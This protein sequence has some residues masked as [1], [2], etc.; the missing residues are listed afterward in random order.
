MAPF[1]FWSHLMKI[2][3]HHQERA[4]IVAALQLLARERIRKLKDWDT[5]QRLLHNLQIC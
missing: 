2:D 3:I 5:L 4:S 1:F